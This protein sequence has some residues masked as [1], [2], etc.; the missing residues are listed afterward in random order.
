MVWLL[1]VSTNQTVR[2]YNARNV[3]NFSSH[4]AY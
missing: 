3:N 2:M 1:F 4:V